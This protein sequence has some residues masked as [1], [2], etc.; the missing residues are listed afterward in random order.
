MTATFRVS[1]FLLVLVSLPLGQLAGQADA[2]TGTV[3]DS[4]T[5]S[6]IEGAQVEVLHAGGVVVAAA[7]TDLRGN[8]LLQGLASGRYTIVVLRLGYVA[9]RVEDVAPG[10]DPLA[11]ALA[12]LAV[13]IDPMTVTVSRTPQTALEAP[14]SISVV[15]RHEIDGAT[16][17]TP[18]D[19]VRTVTGLDFASKGLIQHSYAT[20]GGRG[21]NSSALLTLVDSRYAAIPSLRFNVPYLI[22][23]TSDDIERIEVV[24]GPASALYGPN[25]A[26][27]VLHWLGP[28]CVF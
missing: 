3:S 1:S 4:A 23:I 10:M 14:A 22:P 26:R 21:S 27:G 6:L 28:G 8:F 17:F 2:I 13:R 9:R 5:G 18:L 12:P 24:R 19:H 25:S 20:R 7:G 16:A 15:D 11:I